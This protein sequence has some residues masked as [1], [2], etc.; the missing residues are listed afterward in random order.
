MDCIGTRTINSILKH[1]ADTWGD[2]EC[3][4]F[5]DRQGR[6]SRYTYRELEAYAAR[7]AALF[8]QNGI[9]RGDKVV[10]HMANCPEYLFILFGLAHIGAVMVPTNTLAT[11]FEMEHY[12]KFSDASAIVTDPTHIEM[13][14]EVADDCEGVKILFLART[15]AWYPNERLFERSVIINDALD[16]DFEA[17]PPADLSPEDDVMILFSSGTPAK[18]SAVMLTH[19]NAVFAGT[20]GSQAWKVRPE[21]RHLMVL[22]LFHVNGLFISAMPTL[23]AGAALIM[24]EQFSASRYMDQARR[25]AATTSSLVAATVRMLLNQP[26]HYLD[27]KNSLRLIMY[28]IAITDEE[29]ELFENRFQ[30]R[31]CDLWGMTETLGATTVNP[32]DG[33]F[34]KNCIGLPRLG[35]EVKIV[36]QSGSEQPHGTPGEIIVKGVPGRTLMKG[37]YKEPEATAEMIRDGW[38]YTGDMGFMDQDGYLYFKDRIKSVIKRAGENISAREVE[39]VLVM[40]PAVA[41]ATVLAVPDQMRDEAVCAFIVLD[42]G[43]ACTEQELIDWCAERMAK[44]K[45]PGIVKF[46]ERIPRDTEGNLQLDLLK[47]EARI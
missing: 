8:A 20:F 32:I 13:I 1:R 26:P 21:D 6:V 28:A 7:Y 11:S 36:D 18:A 34:K 35:N 19:A 24:T 30:V 23:T 29:W 25:H 15:V 46:L 43:Q 37:Y 44:F 14:R 39:N 47:K 3:I 38:L 2:K 33:P 9:R 12:I 17:P 16:A 42:G 10:V 27:N 22:P 4:V 5:E 41:E 40:H 45:V 31:L